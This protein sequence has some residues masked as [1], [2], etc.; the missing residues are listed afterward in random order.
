M[1]RP[2]YDDSWFTSG[3]CLGEPMENVTGLPLTPAL[4]RGYL[5]DMM[6]P[7]E[8]YGRNELREAVAQWHLDLGGVPATG[9]STSQ[10][11]KALADMK[12]AGL[13][14]NPIIGKYR[15]VENSDIPAEKDL[16]EIAQ[17]EAEVSTGEGSQAVY[18]W[19]LPAYRELA[20]LK[21]ESR[22]A[23]KIGKTEQDVMKRA[24]THAGTAPE[25]PIIG[26]LLKDDDA[27]FWEG[28]LHSWLTRNGYHRKEAIGDE[29]F[30]TNPEEL[31]C[32]Y[33]QIAAAFQP[34]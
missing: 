11:K 32:I 8:V 12:K 7:E 18:G 26:F 33:E 17:D 30:D 22:F 13:V 31:R 29:W 4:I 1:I 19:Y 2:I 21:G 9:D 23:M 28:Q 25:Q 15:L 5:L 16:E 34:L 6:E 14:E 27:A 3:L 24:T 20:D 10:I